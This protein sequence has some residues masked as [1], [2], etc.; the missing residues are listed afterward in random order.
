[1][2][3]DSIAAYMQWERRRGAS[4]NALRRCKGFTEHLYKWLPEDKVVTKAVLHAWRK[5]LKDSGYSPDTERN[6]IKGINRYLDYVGRPDLRF[7]RGRARD[8]AGKQFGY[9]LAIEPTG[10]MDR[11]D[12]IWLC[13]CRCGRTLELPATRL[14]T[15][16]TLSCGCLSGE[17]LKKANK[18]CGGTSLRQ[19]M[20][21]QTASTRSSSGYTGVTSKR[22]K[23]QAYIQYRGKRYSLGS[24]TAL[25]DAVKARARAKQLVREDAQALL[26]YYE[27]LHRDDPEV[28]KREDVRAAHQKTEAV[29]EKPA[30]ARALRSNNTSGCAGVYPKNGRWAARITCRKT[31]YHLGTFADRDSA[32]SARREAERLWA[33]DPEKFQEKYKKV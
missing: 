17:N 9:L 28:P 22:G 31:T 8:I 5:S 32:V 16:N 15:G 12:R 14:L 1:M 6:Y 25:E 13:R 18:Y 26:E 7:D 33:A 4:E 3:P 27:S 29:P 10:K 24:Y 30:Q 21:E 23:W 20:A 11:K 19:S 2:S